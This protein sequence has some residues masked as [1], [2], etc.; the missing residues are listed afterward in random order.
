MERCHGPDGQA[1]STGGKPAVLQ[2]LLLGQF[3][4][5]EPVNVKAVS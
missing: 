5:V 4:V 1:R 3:V 2:P